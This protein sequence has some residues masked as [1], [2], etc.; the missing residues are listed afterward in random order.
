MLKLD[1]VRRPL[2]DFTTLKLLAG[3][4]VLTARKNQGLY[5]VQVGNFTIYIQICIH[6]FMLPRFYIHETTHMHIYTYKLAESGLKA[7]VSE[8][9]V[10]L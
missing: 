2:H 5:I 3:M 4:T 6:T 1:D 7:Q 10:S 9:M 8:V